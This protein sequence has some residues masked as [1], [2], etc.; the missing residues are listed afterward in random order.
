MGRDLKDRAELLDLLTSTKAKTYVSTMGKSFRSIEEHASDIENALRDRGGPLSSFWIDQNGYRD[1]LSQAFR[2]DPKRAIAAFKDPRVIAYMTR[3][4]LRTGME[5]TAVDFEER[6][7]QSPPLN[8]VIGRQWMGHALYQRVREY[9][10]K[11]PTEFLKL[12][13][14]P[15]AREYVETYIK[16]RA[17]K[18]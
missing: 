9:A 2:K 17:E 6:L 11:S 1:T 15:A 8:G 14:E 18:K 3:T 5:N 10:E 12:L 13:K 4:Y 7:Q 16:V